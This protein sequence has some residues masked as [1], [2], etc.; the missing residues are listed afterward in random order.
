[1]GGGGVLGTFWYFFVLFGTFSLLVSYLVL[2][3]LCFLLVPCGTFSTFGSLWLFLVT[4]W[5]CVNFFGFN[6][7][8]RAWE[9]VGW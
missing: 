4:F 7:P 5:Y 8:D 9:V 2:L 3:L 1:M 6:N